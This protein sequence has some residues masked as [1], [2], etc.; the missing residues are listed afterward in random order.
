MDF[1]DKLRGLSKRIGQLKDQIPNEEATKMAF[2]I[3]FFEILG[4]DTRNPI[5]FIPEY[6]ADFAGIKK[7]EKVDY[8]IFINGE[9]QILVE[10]KWC[11][12]ELSKHDAQ[13]MRYFNATK[14]KIGILTNGIIYKFFTDLDEKNKMDKTP[15]LEIDMLNLKDTQINELKKFIKAN[16]DIDT[17][18]TSA[19]SLK[20][21]NAVKKLLIEEFNE[22][23]DEFI[24]YI[25]GKV[26]D[27]I[28]TKKVIDKFGKLV[29]DSISQLLNDMVR[30]K[31]EE[32]LNNNKEDTAEQEIKTVEENEDKVITTEEELLAY[33]I[34]KSIL[35]EY[36]P[37]ADVTYKDVKRYFSVL[38]KGS[39]S[40]WICRFYFNSAN[41]YISFPI[42]E[43]Q[44]GKITKR[45]E[46]VLLERIEDIYKFKD[47]LK[48]VL[49]N[50]ISN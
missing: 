21:S 17:I 7:G 38:Y 14:A 5:E 40:K 34:V 8:A 33:H 50:I 31:L 23:S 44:E 10:V 15:F 18:L 9:P 43:T 13:L 12:E 27:G 6:T 28:K 20:Y 24:R 39:I 29:K 26:Y 48:E 35:S 46:K 41:K 22:P 19:E 16:F 42:F 1:A 25:L 47:K 32:A 4:Y 2:V 45:E 11:G 36:I 37:L 30:N 49:D 3:P